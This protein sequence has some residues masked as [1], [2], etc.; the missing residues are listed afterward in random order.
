MKWTHW[1]CALAL[2]SAVA[3]GGNEDEAQAE[4]EEAVNELAAA[5]NMAAEEATAEAAGE[6]AEAA[7]AGGETGMQG[8]AQLGEALGAALE[9]SAMAEGGTPCEQAWNGVQAMM[10]AMQKQMGGEGQGNM[11][12][13]DTFMEACNQLPEQAQQCM[14]PAYA[15]QHMQEC[16]EAQND[17]QVQRIREM[18]R[19]GGGMN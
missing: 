8:L 16:Q 10:A 13:Q 17:P 14:V 4:A 19:G 3:C 6:A 2:S 15:M 1:M 7:E 5:L 18:M 12:S 9:A 11:P